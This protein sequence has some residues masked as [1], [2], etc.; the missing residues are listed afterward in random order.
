MMHHLPFTYE[1]QR[2]AQRLVSLPDAVSYSQSVPESDAQR[3]SQTAERA[4]E[5]IKAGKSRLRVKDL[6]SHVRE[7]GIK[8]RRVPTARSPQCVSTFKFQPCNQSL[9]SLLQARQRISLA[10][11]GVRRCGTVRRTSQQS[12]ET[13]WRRRTGQ[14]ALGF[15]PLAGFAPNEGVW[16]ARARLR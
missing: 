12:A 5:Y 7:E 13:R 4:A 1:C 8:T 11:K 2:S 10:E 15:F 14:A 16:S 9:L 3:Y 6:V